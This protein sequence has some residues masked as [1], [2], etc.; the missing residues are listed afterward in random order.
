MREHL[1]TVLDQLTRRLPGGSVSAEQLAV[2]SGH[3]VAD[4]LATLGPA[5]NYPALLAFHRGSGGDS[6][7]RIL[8]SAAGVFAEKGYRGA[9]LD[10]IAKAA[11]LTKGA[12][13]SNFRNKQDLFF[14]LFD[15]HLVM[16]VG[17]MPA[18]INAAA[19]LGD[20]AKGMM[21]LLGNV[22]RRCQA[23]PYWPRL[24]LE[25]MGESRDEEVRSR[26][27]AVYRKS[28]ALSV[29]LIDIMKRNGQTEPTLD[30]RMLALFWAAL[31]DGLMMAWLMD[32]ERI[33]PDAISKGVVDILWHGI[34]P[35]GT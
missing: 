27:A 5:E 14:A 19:T 18:E 15:E 33:D 28:E 23:D 10:E 17:S 20:A 34:A 11:G 6:R 30:S 9:S 26:L 13:Y 12:I 31:V 21:Q 22:L 7:G 24:A 16:H 29:T 4:V 35:R 1:L 25:F 8:Q 2:A 3:V 32:P